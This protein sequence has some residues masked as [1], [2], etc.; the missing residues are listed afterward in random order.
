MTNINCKR[1]HKF[2]K[3]SLKIFNDQFHNVA[4]MV[5]VYVDDQNKVYAGEWLDKDG[6]VCFNGGFAP[7]I[8]KVVTFVDEE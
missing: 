8:H 3:K 7:D 6:M 4:T 1:S 2:Y 5:K